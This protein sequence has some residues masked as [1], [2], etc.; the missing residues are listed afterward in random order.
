M[1]NFEKLVSSIIENENIYLS[2]EQIKKL[3][4]TRSKVS[5]RN[6]TYIYYDKQLGYIINFM[7][8]ID[9]GTSDQLD[10]NAIFL[11]IAYERNRGLKN[12]SINKRINALKQALTYCY[13]NKYIS[14][15]KLINVD[16]LEETKTEILIIN[17]QV[18]KQILRYLENNISKTEVIRARAIIYTLLDTGVRKNE[19]R[20]LTINNLDL[21]NNMIKLDFT[22]TKNDRTVFISDK[23]KEVL[24]DYINVIHPNKYIF[25][26]LD[27]SKQMANQSL[28]SVISKIKRKL[29]LP[30]EISISFHKFRHTYATMCYNAGADLEFIRNTLGHCNLIVTERYLHKPKDLMLL[31]HKKYAPVGNIE[32]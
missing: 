32:F 5:N 11:Y 29:N 17:E 31:D 2:L 8:S 28:D 19:L 15:N 10:N 6:D 26:T 13:K 24:R 7:K 23:T 30:R 22:K 20:H 4:L 3:Y 1:N 14:E 12:I 25:T 27:G 9:I 21:E 18:I 16:S